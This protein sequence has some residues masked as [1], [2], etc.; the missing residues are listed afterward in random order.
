MQL[1]ETLPSLP[2]D[3]TKTQVFRFTNLLHRAGLLAIP[4]GTHVLRFLP[5]LTLREA[6]AAEALEII[7]SV[8]STLS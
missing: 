4:A 2:G 5:A 3:T 6:E 1:A 7:E 8:V